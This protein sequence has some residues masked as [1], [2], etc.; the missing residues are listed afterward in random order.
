MEATAR[1]VLAEFENYVKQSKRLPAEILVSIAD[2]DRPDRMAD[3]IAANM[4]LRVGQ[5]QELLETVSAMERLEK[6]A[7]MLRA[8]MDIIELER[9]S[10]R[11]CASRWRRLRRSTNSGSR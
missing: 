4:P 10:R 6:L 3:D 1:A 7:A 2:V 5:K 9:R 11:A 8:E